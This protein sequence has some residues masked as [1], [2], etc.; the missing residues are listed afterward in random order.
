MRL[1]DQISKGQS[2]GRNKKQ[3]WK[4]YIETG[5]QEQRRKRQTEMLTGKSV[6]KTEIIWKRTIEELCIE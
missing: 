3:V 2:E 4:K 6:R 5:S 1:S